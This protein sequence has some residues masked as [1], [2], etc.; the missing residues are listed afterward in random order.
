M[1]RSR[2]SEERKRSSA[3]LLIGVLTSILSAWRVGAASML[4]SMF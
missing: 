3:A 2:F 1:K 4:P